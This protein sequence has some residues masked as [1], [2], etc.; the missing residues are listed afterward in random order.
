MNQGIRESVQSTLQCATV[1]I[2]SGAI[3]NRLKPSAVLQQKLLLP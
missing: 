2:D 1:K 3:P